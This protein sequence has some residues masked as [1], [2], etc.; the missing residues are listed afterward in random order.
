VGRV[1]LPTKLSLKIHMQKKPTLP[2]NSYAKKTN[3]PSK[4]IDVEAVK[5]FFFSF[6]VSPSPLQKN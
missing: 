1:L 3:S 4:L 6:I 5:I 2:Q